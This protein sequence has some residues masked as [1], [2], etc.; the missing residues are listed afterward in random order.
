MREAGTHKQ[1]HFKVSG[2]PLFTN[3]INSDEDQY[4]I[5]VQNLSGTFAFNNNTEV[6]VSYVS[7]GEIGPRG[8]TGADS[9]VP[10]PIGPTGADSTVLWTNRTYWTILLFSGPRGP[11]GPAST[12]PGPT[13]ELEFK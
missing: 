5:P 11:T 12:I 6:F 13:G 3:T 10:G 9:T 8:A 2:L 4:E 7:R 1:A